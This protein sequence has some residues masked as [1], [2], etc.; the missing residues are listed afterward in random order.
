MLIKLNEGEN[1]KDLYL[2]QKDARDKLE[3]KSEKRYNMKLKE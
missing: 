1:I 3:F 2:S